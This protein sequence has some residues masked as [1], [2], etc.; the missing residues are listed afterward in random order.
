MNSDFKELLT[1]LNDCRV[2]YLVVGG[3]AY[4]HYAEPRYTKDIDLWILPTI[5]NAVRLREALVRFGGW[6]EGM[7]LEHFTTERTMFQIGL[8]PCRVDFLTSVPGLV[9][10]SAF[11]ERKV[12]DIGGLLVPLISLADLILA[13]RT[14]GREQDLRDLQGLERIASGE[15]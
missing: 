5:E 10:E 1:I 4:I 6:V 12:A 11:A 8:P 3:Y 13:K 2:S 9:F 7:T 15:D 14:S